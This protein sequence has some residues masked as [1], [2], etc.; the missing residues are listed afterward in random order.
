MVKTQNKIDASNM[1]QDII[2][3]PKQL[4]EALKFSKD[5][6]IEGTFDNIIVCGLGGSALPGNVLACWLSQSNITAP[7]IHIHRDY[8]LPIQI[9]EG[10][11]VVCISY[12]GN[13]E[14]TL[15]SLNTALAK[16]LTVAAITTGGKMQKICEDNN[17]PW[18]KIPSGLQPR[19]ALG[20]Q[21]IALLRLLSNSGAIPDTTEEILE[22]AKLLKS[23]NFEKQGKKLAQKL[24][25]KIPLIYTS[26]SFKALGRIWK[27]K[28]NESSKAPAFFNYFPELNHNEM[29][30]FTNIPKGV[31]LHILIIRDQNE[32]PRNLKRMELFAKLVKKNKV[33]VDFIELES[34]TPL[35][36]IFSNTILADWTSYYLALEYKTDPSPVEIVE[37]LKRNLSK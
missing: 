4:E 11:L 19:M 15:S 16:N 17:L 35:F 25:N 14:E 34:G 7:T 37:E 31:N 18:I 30:G 13:T 8:G 32:N 27:I 29:V 28:F 23:E 5:I 3:F 12:S 21:F 1:R 10:S 9:R 2:N 20:Y 26:N 22:T 36:K 24:K 33:G 6:K